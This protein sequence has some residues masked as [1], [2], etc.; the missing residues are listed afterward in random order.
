MDHIEKQSSLHKS[1]VINIRRRSGSDIYV[2]CLVVKD[3]RSN[4]G[5]TG[6]MSLQHQGRILV[7]DEVIMPS[8][9]FVVCVLVE[10]NII[11]YIVSVMKY[12]I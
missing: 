7:P 3:L 12:I 9:S 10:S 2:L 11:Y 8:G 6:A 4:C 1:F 5:V